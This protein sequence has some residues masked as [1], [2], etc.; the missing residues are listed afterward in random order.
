M[1]GCWGM[2]CCAVFDVLRVWFSE[3]GCIVCKSVDTINLALILVKFVKYYL[4]CFI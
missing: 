3:M 1:N 2:M 4:Y